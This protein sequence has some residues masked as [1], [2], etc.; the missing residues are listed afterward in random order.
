ML[1]AALVGA[2]RAAEA[3]AALREA[4]AHYQAGHGEVDRATIRAAAR[5]GQAAAAQGRYEEARRSLAER[6]V[7][8]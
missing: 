3:E 8:F 5:T 1:A 2:G 4:H 6:R 7:M